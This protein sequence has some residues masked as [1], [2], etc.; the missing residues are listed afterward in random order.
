M[1]GIPRLPSGGSASPMAPARDLPQ[2][3]RR[4]RPVRCL[5]MASLAVAAGWL[6]LTLL[7][8][9]LRHGDASAL[10]AAHLPASDTLPILFWLKL[11]IARFPFWLLIAVA[12]F[13]RFSGGLTSA[14]TVYRGLCDGAVLGFLST[15][16]SGHVPL[17]RPTAFT[18][19]HLITAFSVWAAADLL[20]RL[21]MTLAARQMAEAEWERHE[22][23]HRVSPAVKSALWRYLAVCLGGLCATLVTCGIYTAFLYI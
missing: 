16:A 3:L 1:L 23:D 19:P 14:V 9:L 5:L 4:S 2:L 10:L 12:G 8:P 6:A 20:I 21:V 15:A 22:E 7:L 17:I 13:T 18:Y 11:C